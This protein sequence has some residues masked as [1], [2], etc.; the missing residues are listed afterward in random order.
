MS[1]HRDSRFVLV[2]RDGWSDNEL[3]EA[4]SIEQ[5]QQFLSQK[6]GEK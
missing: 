1:K 6:G 4:D 2:E 3:Y 5:L